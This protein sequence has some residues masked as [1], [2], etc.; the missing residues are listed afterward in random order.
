MPN[1]FPLS[2]KFHEQPHALPT[3]IPTTSSYGFAQ[4]KSTQCA[5]FET[6]MFCH[7]QCTKY[8]FKRF[9]GKADPDG[10]FD[11]GRRHAIPPITDFGFRE[12]M[13][14]G[15]SRRGELYE[16]P[17]FPVPSGQVWDSQRSSLPLRI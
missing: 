3:L 8:L 1:R 4:E 14:D 7:F 10:Q 15:P 13:W 5:A 11:W 17:N 12:K 9:K 16:S 6:G 2:T